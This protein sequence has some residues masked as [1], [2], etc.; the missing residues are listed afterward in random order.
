[1]KAIALILLS[2]ASETNVACV[3]V[4]WIF[5]LSTESIG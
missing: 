2:A 1:M 3:D 5:Q 4:A